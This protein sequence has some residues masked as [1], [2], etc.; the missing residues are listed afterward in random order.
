[1]NATWLLA[2]SLALSLAGLLGLIRSLLRSVRDARIGAYPLLPRQSVEFPTAGPVMLAV[3]GPRFTSGFRRLGF[4][5]RLPGGASVQGRRVLLRNTTT[6]LSSVRLTLQRYV[7]PFAGRY[8]LLVNGLDPQAAGLANH[9]LVFVAPGMSR[10]ISLVVGIT[11]CAGWAIASLVFLL[12]E[13]IP[14]AGAID[15]GRADGH[16]AID[17][18]RLQLIHA[19]AQVHRIQSGRDERSRELRVAI[20]DREIPQLTLA[21]DEPNELMRLAAS[22]K[23][24]GLLL[25]LDPERAETATLTIL[26]TGLVD[27]NPPPAT[28]ADHAEPLLRRYSLSAQRVGGEIRC[29]PAI[30]IDCAARFSAPVFSD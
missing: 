8:E 21:G 5:L 28:L 30:G 12:L 11:L 9:R 24:R 25:R 14:A 15:P 13:V 29:P 20:T 17:G 22:G 18:E 26:S 6:G 7:L 4:E 27:G 23:C 10:R 2:G 19:Y 3:E 1:M 16:V